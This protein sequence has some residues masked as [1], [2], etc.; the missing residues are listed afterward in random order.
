MKSDLIHLSAQGRHAKVSIR[1]LLLHTYSY[2]FL[3]CFPH[4]PHLLSHVSE[5]SPGIAFFFPNEP[6]LQQFLAPSLPIQLFLSTLAQTSPPSHILISQRE[7]ERGFFHLLLPIYIYVRTL[8]PPKLFEHER[9]KKEWG[10][11]R[12]EEG[13]KP[14]RKTFR[15]QQLLERGRLPPFPVR[16]VYL[17]LAIAAPQSPLPLLKRRIARHLPV[18]PSSLVAR[19]TEERR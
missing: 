11:K 19:A 8:S 3:L 1:D 5:L 2:S 12:K 17:L 18:R 10:E 16:I 6:G 9:K 14:A 15:S 4:T 7:R 13:E